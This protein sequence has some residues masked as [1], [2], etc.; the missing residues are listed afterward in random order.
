LFLRFE[1]YISGKYI[2]EIVRHVL[3]AMAKESSFFSNHASQKLLQ[4]GSFTAKH[5][6]EIEE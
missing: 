4:Y 5:I 3:I 6:S 2:G 1:K